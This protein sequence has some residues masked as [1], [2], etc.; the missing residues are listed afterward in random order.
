MAL[1]IQKNVAENALKKAKNSAPED[2]NL[3]SLIKKSLQLI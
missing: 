2:N 1:G 3:E